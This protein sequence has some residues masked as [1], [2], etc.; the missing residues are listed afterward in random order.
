MVRASACLVWLALVILA[1]AVEAQAQPGDA[2]DPA[3]AGGEPA[4]AGGEP[5]APEPPSEEAPEAERLFE[6]GLEDMRIGRYDTGCPAL[7]RSYRLDPLPGAL[8]TLAECQSRWG[9]IAS[10]VA[11]YKDYLRQYERMAPVEQGRQRER[12]AVAK[13]Q[14]ADLEPVLP[15]LTVRLDPS[16]PAGA[17]VRQNGELVAP[18]TLGTA[19]VVDPGAHQ[20]VVEV[21][22]KR[23]RKQIVVIARAE[24]R[25]VVLGAPAESADDDDDDG[26][27]DSAGPDPAAMR[28]G[29][30]AASAVG[31]AGGIVSIVAGAL[32]LAHKSTIENNCIDRACNA[33]GK[34]AADDAAVTGTV[35]TVGFAVGVAGLAAAVVL[36][37]LV[38]DE[39]PEDAA[40][41]AGWGVS[42]RSRSGGIV[43]SW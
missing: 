6:E 33:E 23:P 34:Q 11:H 31:A 14:V 42:P 36:W 39:A 27:D 18:A 32:T 29:A 1:S 15:T 9:K 4:G 2:E 3:G 21:P 13:R 38:P 20:L 24:K 5:A 37:L 10:A 7:A 19:V 28:A 35:S 43:V 16:V 40:G 30:I 17:R 41:S 8:F 26:A 22:G 12:A 25:E